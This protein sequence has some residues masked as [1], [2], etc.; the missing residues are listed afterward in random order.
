MVSYRAAANTTARQK[1]RDNTFKIKKP[2]R[3]RR[4]RILNRRKLPF[5]SDQCMNRLAIDSDSWK[6]LSYL[7]SRINKYGCAWPSYITIG[8]ECFHSGRLENSSPEV[9]RQAAIRIVKRLVAY[10]IIVIKRRKAANGADLPNE[11]Y[12]TPLHTWPWLGGEMPDFQEWEEV[13]EDVI[14]DEADEAE[15]EDEFE[16]SSANVSPDSSPIEEKIF[17]RGSNEP[18]RGEYSGITQMN[19]QFNE[20]INQ[21]INI[22]AGDHPLGEVLQKQEEEKKPELTREEEEAEFAAYFATLEQK[23]AEAKQNPAPESSPV[24]SDPVRI[25]QQTETLQDSAGKGFQPRNQAKHTAVGQFD[26]AEFFKPQTMTQEELLRT[27]YPEKL[28]QSQAKTKAKK[29]SSPF[30]DEPLPTGKPRPILRDERPDFGLEDEMFDAEG[31]MIKLP[32]GAGGYAQLPDEK[33]YKLSRFVTVRN[34]QYALSELIAGRSPFAEDE[35][36]NLL[37]E[38]RQMWIEANDLDDEG[39]LEDEVLAP[40]TKMSLR[41]LRDWAIK[42]KMITRDKFNNLME[43]AFAQAQRFLRQDSAKQFF[44]QTPLP[45]IFAD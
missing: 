27:Y 22:K 11:F 38:G 6:L 3:R 29:Q 40:D 41:A 21:E 20:L 26:P 18:L 7:R 2:L 5:F 34:V 30:Q 19:D 37:I 36:G 10:G 44:D 31:V 25:K 42:C 45:L 8:R 32:L 43:S 35:D 1:S 23:A 16:P 24:N 13:D 14:W 15:F 39:G 9:R 28:E 4:R 33:R 17:A 12:F